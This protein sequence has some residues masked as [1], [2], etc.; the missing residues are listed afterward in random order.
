MKKTKML[1]KNYEFRK[2]LNKGKYFSGKNIEAFILKNDVN[3]NFLGLAI[4]T[5]IGHAFKRNK[6]KRLLRENYKEIEPFIY[7]GYSIV[8]M[9]KKKSDIENITF[10]TVKED[11]KYILRK[12]DILKGENE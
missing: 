1:K 2:V 9:I 12:S 7:D 11:V 10:Q 3:V 8:F 6:L 5:K 4:G